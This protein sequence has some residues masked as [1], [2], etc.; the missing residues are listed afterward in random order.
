MSGYE[1]PRA[2][3]VALELLAGDGAEALGGGTDLAGRLHTGHAA[4]TILVDLQAVG[5]AGVEPHEGGLRIGATTTLAQ[6]ARAQQLAPYAAVRDA[7]RSAA[8]S[9]LRTVATVGGNL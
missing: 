6:L 1:R 2:L 8:S 9:L 4:P 3:D 7:A 5:L